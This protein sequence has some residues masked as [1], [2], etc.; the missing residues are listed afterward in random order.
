MIGPSYIAS[1]EAFQQ[2]LDEIT[3]RHQRP[4]RVAHDVPAVRH[5]P[6]IVITHE[7]HD[8]GSTLAEF[9]HAVMCVS[10]LTQLVIEHM[11]IIAPNPY[12]A[13]D[14]TAGDIVTVDET[15][16]ATPV[17]E[18]PPAASVNV[19]VIAEDTTTGEQTIVPTPAPSNRAKKKA[20]KTDG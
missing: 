3:N 15:G 13:T 7:W 2:Y 9:A 20:P 14:L 5:Y 1:E 8:A 19:A 18:L 12:A 11:P 17:E 4:W 16:A 10:E 6:A